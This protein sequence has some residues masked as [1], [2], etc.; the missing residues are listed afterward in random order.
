MFLSGLE[1][2]PMC[3]LDKNKLPFASKVS[4]VSQT[5]IRQRRLFQERG[6]SSSFLNLRVSSVWEESSPLP[7]DIFFQVFLLPRAETVRIS[8]HA[9]SGK[10]R[11]FPDWGI[12]SLSKFS[13]SKSRHSASSTVASGSMRKESVGNTFKGFNTGSRP[14]PRNKIA[15]KLVIYLFDIYILYYLIFIW[16]LYLFVATTIQHQ[17]DSSSLPARLWNVLE[18]YFVSYQIHLVRSYQIYLVRSG[19]RLERQASPA[20]AQ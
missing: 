13:S 12:S 14:S 4:H 7:S 20:A 5:N 10:S 6:N 17:M 2:D 1:S 11:L 3:T 16:Y 9:Q 8:G 19:H 18:I 15:R